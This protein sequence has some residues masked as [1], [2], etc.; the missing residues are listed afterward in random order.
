MQFRL[1]AKFAQLV[2]NLVVLVFLLLFIFVIGL[3]V[4]SDDG[5]KTIHVIGLFN[6]SDYYS[7]YSSGFDWSTVNAAGEGIEQE[8]QIYVGFIDFIKFMTIA[9]IKVTE[10]E[11]SFDTKYDFVLNTIEPALILACTILFALNSLMALQNVFIWKKVK[12]A[13]TIDVFIKIFTI[14]SIAI[15]ISFYIVFPAIFKGKTFTDPRYPENFLPLN[16]NL[17]AK[18][19][20]ADMKNPLVLLFFGSVF[21]SVMMIV[22][23]IMNR[24]LWKKAQ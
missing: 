14:T 10:T 20:E 21:P 22:H 7:W 6:K 18:A 2:I 4:E 13:R 5:Q 11:T 1:P 8:S 12:L 15:I 19:Y 24:G 3:K 17:A 16:Q 23:S 9:S